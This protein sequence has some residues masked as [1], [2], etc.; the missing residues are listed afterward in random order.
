MY[1]L[2]WLGCHNKTPQT[3]LPKQKKNCSWMPKMQ[4]PSVLASREPP[5][6]LADASSCCLF[7]WLP[8]VHTST[9]HLGVSKLPLLVRTSVRLTQGSPMCLH[10]PWIT[11]RP[12]SQ[13][14][15]HPEV[16]GIRALN[17]IQLIK[18]HKIE[19][20]LPRI[21]NFYL[22]KCHCRTWTAQR[23]RWNLICI[24]N[25]LSTLEYTNRGWVILSF[26]G[27]CWVDESHRWDMRNTVT[28]AMNKSVLKPG[29]LELGMKGNSI[30]N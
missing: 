14:Q 23:R 12:Y 13:I 16:S 5:L 27:I 29:R 20:L 7:P 17:K 25:S 10:L 19:K 1:V 18:V 2:I 30:C 26:Q 22:R 9:R 15:W 24:L 28:M 21:L 6:W 4:L 8:S 3:G 11:W